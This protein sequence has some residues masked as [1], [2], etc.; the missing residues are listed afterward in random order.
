MNNI[1][2]FNFKL[3]LLQFLLCM[4][5]YDKC[6]VVVRIKINK[7]WNTFFHKTRWYIKL[8]WN[9]QPFVFFVKLTWNFKKQTLWVS[10]FF[11]YLTRKVFKKIFLWC[12]FF[13]VLLAIYLYVL[14]KTFRTCVLWQA[15]TRSSLCR[16]NAAPSYYHLKQHSLTV[17]LLF[18]CCLVFLH[19]VRLDL[20]L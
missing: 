9:K 13:C 4:F 12:F 18:T 2:G 17:C 14:H 8:T 1:L 11:N 5:V 19:L 20:T 16:S 10:D 7:I 15:K 6:L 3:N